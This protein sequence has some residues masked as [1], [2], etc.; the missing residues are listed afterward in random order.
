VYEITGRITG[1]RPEPR[2]VPYF[3]DAS[4]L[5]PAYDSAPTLI[6]GPGEAELAHQTD[7]WCAV[8]RLEQA[9]EIY[10]EIA[11]RWCRI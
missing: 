1:E 5:T 7:E 8:G 6:L 4:A 10:A 9:V 11:R 2:A 3:T